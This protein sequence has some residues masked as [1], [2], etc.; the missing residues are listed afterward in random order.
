MVDFNLNILVVE[1]ECN[2]KKS[3]TMCF[4]AVEKNNWFVKIYMHR[5]I[6]R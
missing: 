3:C 1:F 5:E 4:E 2:R 6:A